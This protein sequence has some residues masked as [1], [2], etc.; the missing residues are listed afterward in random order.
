MAR[1]SLDPPRTLTYRI[2]KWLT[3]RKFGTMLDPARA[4]GHSPRVSTACALLELQI[5]RWKSVDRQIQ[6]L[7]VM[8]SAVAIG[9]PWCVDFGYWESHNHGIPAEKIEAIQN[10]S[11]SDL[12]A[13][14][15]RLVL[16]YATAMT[17]TPPAV[18]DEMIDALRE[19][20]SERQMVELTMLVAVE[21]MRSRF[22]AAVGLSGQGFRDRCEIAPSVPR[23]G[24]A[25]GGGT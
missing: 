19:H 17:V 14:L 5:P 12:F 7:A 20:L 16:S 22:N 25:E 1:I 2:G 21:N 11:D 24:A 23:D 15:E 10:W 4:M 3:E 9:C 18:T 6:D 13:P 8:A